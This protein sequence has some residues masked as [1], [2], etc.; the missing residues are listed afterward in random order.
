MDDG[1]VGFGVVG[2]GGLAARILRGS[3][4]NRRYGDVGRRGGRR[5]RRG[6][7]D[8]VE[9]YG[10][11]EK[12][13]N[14]S[15]EVQNELELVVMGMAVGDELP[16]AVFVLDHAVAVVHGVVAD[17]YQ[18]IHDEDEDKVEAELLPETTTIPA[19]R[20]K[21]TGSPN[22]EGR[23]KCFPGDH[24]EP[25]LLSILLPLQTLEFE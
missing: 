11:T 22:E 21:R 12:R 25:R 6:V 3:V 18:T 9:G 4:Q 10:E 20:K 5:Q 15:R 7:E 1:H 19:M 23:Q 24:A 8:E 13:G 14:T 2:I 16:F 17:G